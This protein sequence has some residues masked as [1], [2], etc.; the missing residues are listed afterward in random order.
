MDWIIGF[1]MEAWVELGAW[2]G[3]GRNN[4]G[5]LAS[6]F[7]TFFANQTNDRK[8]HKFWRATELCLIRLA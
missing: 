2:S 7:P 3:N 1:E 6:I 5:H 8:R 4:T